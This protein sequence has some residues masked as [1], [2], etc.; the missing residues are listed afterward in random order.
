MHVNSVLLS[1]LVPKYSIIVDTPKYFFLILSIK[2]HRKMVELNFS[3]LSDLSQIC[4]K[5]GNHFYGLNNWFIDPRPT[6][7]QNHFHWHI[8]RVDFDGHIPVFS[9]K[10][11][12][13]PASSAISTSSV[14]YLQPLPPSPFLL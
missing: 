9:P 3:E 11:P 7:S 10:M 8:R 13:Y 1:H 4:S 5:L 6:I 12:W 2:E 14:S